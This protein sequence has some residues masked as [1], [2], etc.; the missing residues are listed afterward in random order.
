MAIETWANVRPGTIITVKHIHRTRP[1]KLR[2]T[3]AVALPKDGPGTGFAFVTGARLRMDGTP[4]T[5]SSSKGLRRELVFL[6]DIV[7]MERLRQYNADGKRARGSSN[8]NQ[9]G[10]SAAR[11]ARKAWLLGQFGDGE[12]AECAFGCGAVLTLDTITVDRFP[13]PGCQGGT[14][15]RG[16]IRPACSTCNSSRGAVLRRNKVAVSA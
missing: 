8:M 14:Y 2:V 3:E 9:R 12:K 5:L 16:N 15:V 11:R 6:G 1:F 10:S 7:A 13:L 4:S